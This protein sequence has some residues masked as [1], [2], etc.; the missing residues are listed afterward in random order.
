MRAMMCIGRS[1]STAYYSERD[2]LQIGVW[3]YQLSAV[4]PSASI[5]RAVFGIGVTP[6][7]LLGKEA[8][9]SW[10]WSSVRNQTCSPRGVKCGGDGK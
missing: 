10:S 6:E 8:P 4:A 5:S 7:A 3:M 9:S 1:S 2:G